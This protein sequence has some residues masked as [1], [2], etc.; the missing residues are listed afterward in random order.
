MQ[1]V[2]VSSLLDCIITPSSIDS[3]SHTKSAHASSSAYLRSVVYLVMY[4]LC[5]RPAY[6]IPEAAQLTDTALRYLANTCTCIDWIMQPP[7]T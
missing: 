2:K 3:H 6:Q 4:Q 1:A 7:L 5:D